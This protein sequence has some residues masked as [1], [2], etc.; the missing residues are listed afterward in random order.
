MEIYPN[1][2]LRLF[3]ASLFVGG[4]LGIVYDVMRIS[5]VLMGINRYREAAKAPLFRPHFYKPRDPK[6]QRKAWKALKWAVVAVQDFAFC[7]FGGV[8]ISLLLFSHNNGEFRGMVLV[9]VIVG[10]FSYYLT[11]GKLL[12]ASSE[13]VVFALRTVALYAV[14]YLTKPIIFGVR[15]IVTWILGAAKRISQKQRTRRIEK[16]NRSERAKIWERAGNG[17]LP[18]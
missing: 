9:G 12:I 5:R 17:F 3:L 18:K 13:Y 1:L 15:K 8:C 16:Y 2:L 14:Y 4:L 11:L 10:F 7:L 6:P